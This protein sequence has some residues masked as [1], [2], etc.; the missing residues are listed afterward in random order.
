MKRND[1]LRCNVSLAVSK[2]RL[3]TSDLLGISD[4]LGVVGNRDNGAQHVEEER[5]R[6][7]E[8]ERE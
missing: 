6:E 1:S 5:E 8:R 7:R 2:I 3:G 4:I